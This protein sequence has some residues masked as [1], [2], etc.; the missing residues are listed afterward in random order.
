VRVVLLAHGATAAVRRS[1]FP[2][3]E[4]LERVDLSV[5]DLP[6]YQEVRSAPSLRCRQTADALS[7]PAAVDPALAGLDHGRWAGRT[8]DE[9]ATAEPDEMT[10]WLTDPESAPHDGESMADFVAR[11]GAWL[12]ALPNLPRGLLAVVDPAVVRA[13][14]AHTLGAPATAVWR[15]DVDPLSVTVL[16]GEADRWNLRELRTGPNRHNGSPP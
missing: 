16:V 5:S 1:A 3:D 13:A 15:V 12:R 2:A 10:R 14:L 11:I 7:L 8:L 9:V 6:G 4:P